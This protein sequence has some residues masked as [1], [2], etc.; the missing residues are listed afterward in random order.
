MASIDGMNIIA[1]SA[2]TEEVLNEISK[3]LKIFDSTD[4]GEQEKLYSY[5]V[6]PRYVTDLVEALQTFSRI[7]QLVA[8]ARLP[9]VQEAVLPV[10]RAVI[11]AGQVILVM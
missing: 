8:A 2:P 4:S 3:W 6:K 1:F 11:I 5:P 7:L 10:E 9:V